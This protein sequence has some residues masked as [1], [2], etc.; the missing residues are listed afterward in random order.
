MTSGRSVVC[1]IVGMASCYAGAY[2]GTVFGVPQAEE[3]LRAL[4]RAIES[5]DERQIAQ[6]LSIAPEHAEAAELPRKLASPAGR[7]LVLPKLAAMSVQSVD[8]FMRGPGFHHDAAPEGALRVLCRAARP[9]EAP[10]TAT[11]TMYGLFFVPRGGRWCLYWPDAIGPWQTWDYNWTTPER[12]HAAVIEALE[13]RDYSGLYE[14][15]AP[16]ARPTDMAS[17]D[18]VGI[19]AARQAVV[20]RWEAE[21]AAER[22]AAQTTGWPAPGSTDDPPLIA[23]R[24]RARSVRARYLDDAQTV[25]QVSHL[26]D[27]AD[28]LKGPVPYETFVK[29]GTRWY[30]QPKPEYTLWPRTGDPPASQPAGRPATT[31][32]AS[33]PTSPPEGKAK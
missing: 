23:I 4:V 11:Y 12:A 9:G 21:R 29:R 25:A 3:A 8:R 19:V 17:S 15:L 5:G 14:M 1:V 27:K 32:P 31:Q 33:G 7:D 6:H 10:D 22:K 24:Y 18:W 2:D 30:W 28:K 26:W 20:D 13:H 16:D